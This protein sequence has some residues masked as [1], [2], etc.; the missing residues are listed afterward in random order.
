MISL[1]SVAPFV[2]IFH[3][4]NVVFSPSFWANFSRFLMIFCKTW[5]CRAR[6]YG[7][8]IKIILESCSETSNYPWDTLSWHR[9]TYWRLCKKKQKKMCQKRT[10]SALFL[11]GGYWDFSIAEKTFRW[12]I[13]QSI[14]SYFQQ[15]IKVFWETR[16]H[17]QALPLHTGV[18]SYTPH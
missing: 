8:G 3:Q 18:C 14:L 5:S 15:K 2:E 1:C 17:G 16:T 12:G 9:E 10:K 11:G 6:R 7:F 13:A 4:K